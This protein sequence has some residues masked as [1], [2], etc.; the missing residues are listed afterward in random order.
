MDLLASSIQIMDHVSTRH[1]V[2]VWCIVVALDWCSSLAIS[3]VKVGERP[4]VSWI[5]NCPWLSELGL[6]VRTPQIGVCL[7]LYDFGWDW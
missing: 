7:W 4:N 3:Q 5:D 6:V 1:M 2:V